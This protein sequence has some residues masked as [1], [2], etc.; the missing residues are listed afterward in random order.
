MIRREGVLWVRISL[1]FCL[2][3]YEL[4][5]IAELLGVGDL[6]SEISELRH[7]VSAWDGWVG[8]RRDGTA[9]HYV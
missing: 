8:S 5:R 3:F 9:E 4:C 6:W 7:P 2:C 1:T